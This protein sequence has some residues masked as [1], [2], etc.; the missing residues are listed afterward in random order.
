MDFLYFIIVGAISGWL[1]NLLIGKGG[2]GLVSNLIVGIVG[3]LL[4]GWLFSQFGSG[5]AVSGLNL[6]SILVSF[7]GAV[8]FLVVL[9][10]IGR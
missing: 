9:R 4:G 5:Q 8:V 2:K 6:E 3:A 1:A 10:L 7:V